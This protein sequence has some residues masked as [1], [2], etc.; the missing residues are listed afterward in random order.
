MTVKRIRAYVFQ[1]LRKM[2][3]SR[4]YTSG[5]SAYYISRNADLEV[6]VSDHAVPWTFERSYNCENGGSSW[7]DSPF[8]LVIEDTITCLDAARW[9]VTIRNEL[10]NCE[11]VQMIRNQRARRALNAASQ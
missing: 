8:S 11:A 10:R 7:A 3:F 1:W 4:E 6:R 5:R 2:G 9:L